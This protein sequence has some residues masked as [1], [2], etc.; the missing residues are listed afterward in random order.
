MFIPAPGDDVAG[1]YAAGAPCALGGKRLVPP[2]L[3]DIPGRVYEPPLGTPTPCVRML[4]HQA[5]TER[6]N[7][8]RCASTKA[9]RNLLVSSTTCASAVSAVKTCA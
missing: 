5:V 3:L 6:L 8:V 2:L 9:V 7:A 1:D 4:W